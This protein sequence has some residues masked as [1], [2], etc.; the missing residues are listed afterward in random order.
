MRDAT[1]KR[2]LDTLS[3]NPRIDDIENIEFNPANGKW[4]AVGLDDE[5]VI[6]VPRIG[7]PRSSVQLNQQLLTSV[8]GGLKKTSS[9]PMHRAATSPSQTDFRSVLKRSPNK[10]NQPVQ[11][12]RS[13]SPVNAPNNNL[14][15]PASPSLAKN[16]V[17][18]NSLDPIV[19]PNPAKVPP[20]SPGVKKM[21]PAGVKKMNNKN[22]TVNPNNIGN[23]FA[24]PYTNSANNR[25]SLNSADN[26]NLN[27]S[28]VVNPAIN[29]NKQVNA[30]KGHQSNNSNANNMNNINTMNSAN[31]AIRPTNV[32]NTNRSPEATQPMVQVQQRATDMIILSDSFSDSESDSESSLHSAQ[33]DVDSDSD[34][35]V[36][37]NIVFDLDLTGGRTIV[38]SSSTTLALIK[39]GK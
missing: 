21:G 25:N 4:K 28:N 20:K 5:H 3:T 29:L 34:S 32:N 10:D 31:S 2:I 39:N 27:N 24:I 26:A 13:A 17:R 11:V 1:L 9:P 37:D 22:V 23:S 14:I 18:R 6:T 7:G 19:H 8:S 15:H 30:F 33:S 36:A 35:Q 38:P 16:N 12:T